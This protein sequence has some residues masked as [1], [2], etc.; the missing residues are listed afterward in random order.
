MAQS[1]VFSDSNAHANYVYAVARPRDNREP[2]SLPSEGIL[3]HS[4]IQTLAYR[5]VMAVVSPV[6]LTVF[7]P[8]ALEVHL[9]DMDWARERV[10]AHQRVLAAILHE[11]TLLPFKFCTLYSSEKQ[12]QEM[13]ARHYGNLDTTLKRLERAFEWGVK[14]YCDLQKVVDWVQESS[15]VFQPQREKIAQ[16]STG[17]SYFLQ[18][19]LKQAAQEQA[20]QIVDASLLK[21]HQSLDQYIKE[22]ITNP[23]QALQVHGREAEM[24]FNG[25]YLVD[26]NDFDTF[27]EILSTL[28]G[29]YAPQGFLFELT[30][31]WPPYN[32]VVLEL[33]EFTHESR[34]ME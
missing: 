1:D 27:Q 10:L 6:P 30:G 22:F 26:E 18:K 24:V 34:T 17:T 23:I 9:Q 21:I 12:V 33:E 2:G 29:I 13:L 32:F 7:K 3:P 4:P 16:A 15:P 14:I 31:P 20:Y 28:E 25:A 5:D 8:P 19:K 11:Y